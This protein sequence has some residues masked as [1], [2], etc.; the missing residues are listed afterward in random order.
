MKKRFLLLLAVTGVLSFGLLASANATTYPGNG[1][2]GF[3]GGVG[4]GSLTLT[5][6]A[7]GDFVFS[8]TLGSFRT[9]LQGNDIA[10][11]IDNGKGGGIGTDTAGLTDTNDGGR[12][13]VS[14]YSGTQRSTTNFAG[15][16]NPQFGLDLSTSNASVYGLVNG[17]TFSFNGGQTVGGVSNGG[18]TYAVTVGDGT[19]TSTV[20]TMTVPAVDL[21]LTANTTAALK[22]FAIQVSETGY[23][24]NEATVGITGNLGYG[25]TQ[26]ITSVNNYLVTVPEPGTWAMLV[27]GALGTLVLARLR[28]QVVG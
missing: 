17:G 11:Y 5:N 1:N 20:F 9:D 19:N 14:E 18:V 22:L 16:L 13:A 23:S 12:Q 8:F 27:T 25:S 24:S 6:N 28:K 2:A 3:N 10:V 7:N 4:T 21:G 26:T 15:L